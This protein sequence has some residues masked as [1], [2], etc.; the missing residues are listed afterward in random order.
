M[1][2]ITYEKILAER[3][4]FYKKY[5]NSIVHSP[6]KYK[7]S[8]IKELEKKLYFLINIQNGQDIDDS[9]IEDDFS[10][11]RY[12]KDEF[13]NK[14]V[15]VL[16]AGSGRQMK[17]LR[18]LGASKV[19][20]I[21]LG[22]KNVKFAEEVLNEKPIIS[23]MH[24]MPFES[25][26]VDTIVGFHVL[27]HSFMP[28]VLMLEC[29]RVLRTGGRMIVETPPMKTGSID[30][31]LHHIICPTPRQLYYMFLKSGFKPVF[32]NGNN[33]ENTEIDDILDIDNI[34]DT[35]YM[36]AVKQDPSSY[37][38][39]DIARYYEILDGKSFRF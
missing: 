32:F 17:F 34:E 31:W 37:D 27:E 26:S 38:R 19:L 11:I 4:E 8:E 13:L 29:N 6:Y 25:S 16:G 35:I 7:D 36:E 21:T 22:E 23:D 24:C 15:L 18:S 39:G 20:G 30:T 33:I 10:L 14:E 28:I 2:L 9:E 5:Q 12:A 3:K 1:Y